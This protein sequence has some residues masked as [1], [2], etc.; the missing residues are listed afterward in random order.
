MGE[1]GRVLQLVDYGVS[2]FHLLDLMT[3]TGTES[4]K[5][6]KRVR[7]A[8]SCHWNKRISQDSLCFD[9]YNGLT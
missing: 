6:E 8:H 4:S 2:H 7:I 9:Y 3:I 1:S 5:K